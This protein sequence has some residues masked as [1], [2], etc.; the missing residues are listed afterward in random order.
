MSQSIRGRT[1]GQE[2]GRVGYKTCIRDAQDGAGAGTVTG[3]VL[4]QGQGQGQEQARAKVA[5]I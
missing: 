1:M 4:G 2:P 3:T 5:E